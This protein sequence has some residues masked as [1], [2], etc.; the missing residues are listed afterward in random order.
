MTILTKSEFVEIALRKLQQAVGNKK[1]EK[2]EED[3]T[4]AIQ[5]DENENNVMNLYLGNVWESYK[6]TD[7]LNVL[8]GFIDVQKSIVSNIESMSKVN[9]DA[10]YPVFRT[11]SFGKGAEE[12]AEEKETENTMIQD[13]YSKE[14]S[15]YYVQ[16]NPQ[17]VSFV[18]RNNDNA[19]TDDEITEAAFNN[20]KRQGWIDPVEK[21]D[22]GDIATLYMFSNTDKQFQAQFMVS[23]M[24]RKHLGDYFH[25]ALP[26]R[27]TAIVVA[28]HVNPDE[29]IELGMQIARQMKET[30]VTMYSNLPNPLSH[31]IHAVDKRGVRVLG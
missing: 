23:D 15:I 2:T 31:V 26:N 4:Y 11:V 27:E 30:A 20:L 7:N 29:H 6:R 8:D 12:L 24:Y 5:I 22:I 14:L 3:L 13:D 18:T 10:I 28:F 25:F 21:I 17:F 1:I 19:Y 9:L 16:D